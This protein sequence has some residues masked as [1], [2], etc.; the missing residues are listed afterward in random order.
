MNEPVRENEVLPS[1]PF[2]ILVVDDERGIRNSLGLY[3]RKH[4]YE[5]ELAATGEEAMHAIK[6][7]PF[8]LVV[9]DISLPGPVSGL[10]ILSHVRSHCPESEVMMMTGHLDVDFAIEALKRGAFDYFKKPFLFEEVQMSIRRVEE[11]QKLLE[12]SKEL[13][14]CRERQETMGELHMQFMISLAAMIDAKS[15]YTRA[16]S[17]RVSVYARW[18]AREVGISGTELRTVTIGGKLHD[19]GK[20]G[21]PE[22]VLNKPS[23]L[24][25]EEWKIIQQHPEAGAELLKPISI[26][27]PYLP[28][29]RWHHENWDGTGYPDGLKAEQIPMLVRIVKVADYYDAITSIRPYRS[30]MTLR[31][32]I[33]TLQ[34]ECDRGFPAELVTTFIQL[35]EKAPWKGAK[36]PPATTTV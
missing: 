2:R 16:H 35:V 17:E 26:M 5:V 25:P 27:E 13:E 15:S 34:Q 3:L 6:N 20:I 1:P 24:T 19:I 21:T 32:A 33:D 18:L 4:G 23:R 9:S 28:I 31:E 7:S 14:R 11:R 30:P 12:R 29:V 22:H 8:P 10:D 36:K